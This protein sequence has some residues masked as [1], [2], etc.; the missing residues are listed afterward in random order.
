MFSLF[1]YEQGLV[2]RWHNTT[3]LNLNL[4]FHLP[5]PPMTKPAGE[6]V[7][8]TPMPVPMF[9]TDE[10]DMPESNG[11][12]II[13]AD[14][15]FLLDDIIFDAAADIIFDAGDLG[16]KRDATDAE[17]AS[18]GEY[19]ETSGGRKDRNR[20]HAKRSRLRK[21]FLLEGLLQAKAKLE[22]ENRLLRAAI[23]RHLPK[24]IADAVTE[25]P[26][27]SSSRQEGSA[28]MPETITQQQLNQYRGELGSPDFRLVQALST[29]QQNFVITDPSLPDNPIVFVSQ[30]FLDLTQYSSEEG[31]QL[32]FVVSSS[33]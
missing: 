6:P 4:Q 31:K 8:E 17:L 12:E 32:K 3:Q 13:G 7:V 18:D 30:N 29:A 28:I 16:T 22:N 27:E 14:D 21:K 2:L 20:E 1:P 19:D 23:F 5:P 33:R 9:T 25:I 26:A 15:V 24:P 10:S 11:G